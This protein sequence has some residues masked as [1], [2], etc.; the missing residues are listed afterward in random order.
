MR[1]SVKL[2]DK[3]TSTRIDLASFNEKASVIFNKKVRPQVA[4][5]KAT[6]KPANTIKCNNPI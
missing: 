5:A 1:I 2:T 6:Q 3:N 4:K